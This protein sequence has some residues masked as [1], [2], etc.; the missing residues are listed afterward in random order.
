M[1]GLSTAHLLG[2]HQVI[3]YCFMKPSLQESIS[4]TYCIGRKTSRVDIAMRLQWY[5]SGN[6]VRRPVMATSDH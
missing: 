4:I 3:G 5:L 6:Q 1:W 2:V